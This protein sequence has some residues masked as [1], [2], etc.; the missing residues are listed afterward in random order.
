MLIA[1]SLSAFTQN[2]TR[3][4]ERKDSVTVSSAEMADILIDECMKMRGARYSYGSRGPRAFDCSG[5]TGYIYSK[6]GYELSRSSGGQAT[7]G[8]PVEGSLSNLQK[9]DI[10]VFGARRNSGRIGH[11]GIFIELDSTGTD[12]T[13]IHAAVKGGVIIS[14]LK[15]PYYKQRFMGARRILPDF[16]TRHNGEMAEYEFDKDH[17]KLNQNDALLLAE[18]TSRILL[19]PD[20]NWIYVNADGTLST[21]PDSVKIVLEP[22]GKWSSI[23]MSTHTIPSLGSKTS[24]ATVSK[25]STTTSNVA[26]SHSAA[27]VSKPESEAQYYTIKSG[28]TLS[29]IAR[30]TG[31]SVDKICRLN[32]IST[33]TILKIGRRIRVK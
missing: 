31:T 1:G 7:D 25:P 15:E 14:H 5:F 9:G 20:G 27:D 29:S 26:V 28:D 11:V 4:A 16:I 12:F 17:A 21:P 8:R 2:P 23:K 13:F 22:T 30:R 24:S 33:R 32:N 19:M 10:V 6:F 3:A 18:G